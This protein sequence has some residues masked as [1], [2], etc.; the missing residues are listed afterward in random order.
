MEVLDQFSENQTLEK[1][2]IGCVLTNDN[3]KEMV[4]PKGEDVIRG[5]SNVQ[6]CFMFAARDHIESD[7]TRSFAVICSWAMS[8]P[9]RTIS[10]SDIEALIYQN[11]SSTDEKKVISPLSIKNPH[12]L[13]IDDFEEC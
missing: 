8:N 7:G 2:G 3:E 10:L 1:I 11:N 6:S 12:R 4:T 5:I 9:T 13:G